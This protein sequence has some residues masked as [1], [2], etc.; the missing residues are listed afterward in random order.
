MSQNE[1]ITCCYRPASNSARC[2]KKRQ[3]TWRT[4]TKYKAY[5]FQREDKHIYEADN[6][7]NSQKQIDRETERVREADA[8]ER[9]DAWRFVTWRARLCWPPWLRE[10]KKQKLLDH[11]AALPSSL[12][13]SS[14]RGALRWFTATQKTART[15]GAGFRVSASSSG[16]PLITTKRTVSSSP[17]NF[18][19]FGNVCKTSLNLS[20]LLYVIYFPWQASTLPN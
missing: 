11:Q 2:Q 7:N 9:T 13:L 17:G 3:H 1:R 15:A 19:N 10:W 20:S 12:L 14:L 16:E 6:Q 8:R 5:R 18:G 4:D